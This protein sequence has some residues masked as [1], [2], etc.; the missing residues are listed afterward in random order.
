MLRIYSCE[1]IINLWLVMGKF[2]DT[3]FTLKLERVS[4]AS[5]KL[6]H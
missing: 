2:E 1:D 3:F 5:V 6:C 4:V